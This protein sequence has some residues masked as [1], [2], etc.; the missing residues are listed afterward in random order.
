MVFRTADSGRRT[1]SPT[2]RWAWCGCASRRMAPAPR[3]PS[4]CTTA[5][6]PPRGREQLRRHLRP[7]AH[8]RRQHPRRVHLR[9]GHRRAHLPRRGHVP[10]DAYIHQTSTDAPPSGRRRP[11]AAL[12]RRRAPSRRSTPRRAFAQPAL[13]QLPQ[14]AMVLNPPGSRRGQPRDQLA[15]GLVGALQHRART[16]SPWACG[17][18]PS[19]RPTHYERQLPD[20]GLLRHARPGHARAAFWRCRRPTPASIDNSIF[21]PWAIFFRGDGEDDTLYQGNTCVEPCLDVMQ[22][23]HITTTE[24][25]TGSA[26]STAG[27]SSR[28]P[29]TPPR[30]RTPCAAASTTASTYELPADARASS[31]ETGTYCPSTLRFGDCNPCSKATAAAHRAVPDG[32]RAPVPPGQALHQ[33]PGGAHRSIRPP[34]WS[35]APTST[36]AAQLGIEGQVDDL[37]IMS[38][39]ISPEEMR[40]Y[41]ER[42]QYSAD[43]SRIRVTVM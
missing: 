28:S 11:P 7:G 38:R 32:L 29:S 12:E 30:G 20:G 25:L 1:S 14:R 22:Y 26:S 31:R 9:R 2:A 8:A 18:G 33:P 42:R 16:S 43:E 5:A 10:F 6:H 21:N 27:T 13:A 19:R 41:R 17:C 4:R 35:S 15:L 36:T 39:A 24:P 23:A 34:R 3:P 40:A 37:F